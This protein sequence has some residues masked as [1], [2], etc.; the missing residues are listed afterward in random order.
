MQIS[1]KLTEDDQRKYIS[2]NF[3][4]N[5][6]LKIIPI[7]AIILLSIS[8]ILSFTL[9]DLFYT[10]IIAALLF[11]IVFLYYINPRNLKNKYIR[12]LK[13]SGILGETKTIEVNENNLT[14]SS[15]SRTTVYQHSDVTNVS[16]VND[17]FIY[18]SFKHGDSIVIPKSAFTNEIDMIDFINK[19]KL[20]AKII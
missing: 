4:N 5:S 12:D 10:V 18:I 3:S 17:Y 6:K 9:D 16:V 8:L 14:V 15:L 11:L 2:T 19:I 1:Y 20:Y 7:I 13:A